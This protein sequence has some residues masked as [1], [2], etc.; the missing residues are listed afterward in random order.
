MNFRDILMLPLRYRYWCDNCRREYIYELDGA[1]GHMTLCG[2][3]NEIKVEEPLLKKIF[4][5][6]KKKEIPD[7][8]TQFEDIWNTV[9]EQTAILEYEEKH[10]WK[11]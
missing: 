4:K 6:S 11:P 1:T 7:L 5:K 3:N 8:H 2:E 9:V 10:G